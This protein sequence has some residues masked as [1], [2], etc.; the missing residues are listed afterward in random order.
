MPSQNRTFGGATLD[1]LSYEVDI[2]GKL[3]RATEAARANLLSAE[4][5]RKAVTTTLVSD[6]ASAYFSLRALDYQLEISQRTLATRKDS[7][8]LIQNSP[9]GWRRYAA[10]FA[11]RRATGLHRL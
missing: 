8:G 3:R 5:N 10:R 11:A 9:D 4:E 7:L 1:L 2:W 6:V